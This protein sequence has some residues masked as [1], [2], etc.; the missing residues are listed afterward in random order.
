MISMKLLT[1]ISIVSLVVTASNTRHYAGKPQEHNDP[2]GLLGDEAPIGSSPYY[3]MRFILPVGEDYEYT[4]LEIWN[5]VTGRYLKEQKWTLHG[6]MIAEYVRK[7]GVT[8]KAGICIPI[9]PPHA[10]HMDCFQVEAGQAKADDL[11]IET[12]EKDAGSGL[13]NNTYTLPMDEISQSWDTDPVGF[14]NGE[15][16]TDQLAV[17]ACDEVTDKC[18]LTFAFNREFETDDE[19]RE[20]ISAKVEDYMITYN[21]YTHHDVFAFVD[22]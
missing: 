15:W 4:M 1:S 2:D 7:P 8:Y 13:W 22:R 20:N 16:V 9:Q 12:G 21:E 10:D 5:S 17:E 14:I 3:P 6:R 11:V 18:T 19:E